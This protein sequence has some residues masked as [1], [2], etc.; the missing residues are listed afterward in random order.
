ML[1]EMSQE[2]LNGL[3]NAINRVLLTR[4]TTGGATAFELGQDY[5]YCC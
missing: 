5:K 4:A 2:E 1:G 3:V